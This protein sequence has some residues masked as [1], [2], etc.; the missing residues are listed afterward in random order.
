MP[1]RGARAAR[2][3]QAA[4]SLLQD[5]VDR[6]SANLEGLRDPRRP[7]ALCPQRLHLCR[8]DRRLAALVD[9]AWDTLKTKAPSS[10]LPRALLA[11]L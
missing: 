1:P 7:H 8:I 3:R 10:F 9:P 11:S 6:R 2:S 4:R 5:A